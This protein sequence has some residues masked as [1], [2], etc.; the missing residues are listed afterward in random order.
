MVEAL[1]LAE[2]QV[3]AAAKA[4]RLTISQLVD[5]D[6]DDVEAE[7]ER[8]CENNDPQWGP[9]HAR[10]TEASFTVRL[11][12]HSGDTVQGSFRV[13]DLGHLTFSGNGPLAAPTVL[14]RLEAR[15]IIRGIED[16]VALLA[17]PMPTED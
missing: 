8:D 6:E 10:L 13:D 7:F 4:A 5:L 17:R 9:P 16:L 12:G 14:A 11:P 15:G 2:F 1:Y 3:A